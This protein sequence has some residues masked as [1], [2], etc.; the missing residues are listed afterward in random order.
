MTQFAFRKKNTAIV[1]GI[2]IAAAIVIA[3]VYLPLI[4]EIRRRSVEYNSLTHQLSAAR[5]N[6]GSFKGMEA[7]KRL[8]QERE[9]SSVIDAIAAEG[10]RHLL[11]F[12]AIS[13]EE[14]RHIEENHLILPVKIE[15]EGDYRQLGLF[16][17]ALENI[18]GAVVTAEEFRIWR[19]E[20]ILPKISAAVVL[21]IHLSKD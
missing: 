20:R 4:S 21:N 8:I 19:D 13:Q 18:K 1:S 12:R 11:D 14:L 15:M 17:G 6:L 7:G 2:A 16:F 9:I 3:F 10:R 5:I